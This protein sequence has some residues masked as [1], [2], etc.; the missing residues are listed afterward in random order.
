MKRLSSVDAAFWSAETAGWHMHVGALA[1]CDLTD[2][3]EYN[4]QRLREIMIE[5]LP[6]LPQL[7]WR[8]TG[9]PLGLDRPG[10]VEDEDL[11]LAYHL[12]GIPVPPPR[13]RRRLAGRPARARGAG[14][15]ADVLQAGPVPAA[16]GALGDR[17]CRGRPDRHADQDA[18]CH[19]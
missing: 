9:A 17:G 3:P 7:R 2:A 5:R 6:E 8:V 13:H 19:R 11:D 12:R 16:L 1:I 10:F 14:R 18:P 15:P 4:F